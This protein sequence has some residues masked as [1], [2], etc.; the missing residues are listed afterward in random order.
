MVVSMDFSLLVALWVVKLNQ[1]DEN[2]WFSGVKTA[3]FLAG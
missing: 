2:G 1:S 3:N